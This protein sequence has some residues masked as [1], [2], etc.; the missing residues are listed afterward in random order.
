MALGQ[1]VQLLQR[2]HRELAADLQW[3]TLVAYLSGVVLLQ[4]E[5]VGPRG[6]GALL[7]L[8][9]EEPIQCAPCDPSDN[10]LYT[11]FLVKR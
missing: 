8:D 3:I 2:Q 1:Q 6:A 4:A 7:P 5:P 10:A 9:F 11:G